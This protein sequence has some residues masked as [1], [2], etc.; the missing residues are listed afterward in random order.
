MET[1][2]RILSE[3]FSLFVRYGIKSVTMDDI[4]KHMGIS[5]KTIYEHFRDK[6]DLLRQGLLFHK[7]VQDKN[8]QVIMATSENVLETIYK[9]MFEAVSHMHKVS[10]AFFSDLKKYHHKLCDDVLPRHHREKMQM[11]IELIEKGITEGIFRNDFNVDIVS[12]I[13]NFQLDMLSDE[14]RFPTHSYTR[15]E[16]FKTIIECFTRGIAT[17]KGIAI[18]EDIIEREK[19]KQM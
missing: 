7:D 2:E 16:I 13:M 12:R 8:M 18:I 10:P 9:V 4:A 14:E 19:N 6:D 11:L 3:S 15:A 5:K 17:P 1:Y